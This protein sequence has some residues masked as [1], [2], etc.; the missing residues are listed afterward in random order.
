MDSPITFTPIADQTGTENVP[1]TAVTVSGGSDVTYSAI[2]LP[3]GLEIAPSSGEIT[4]TPS[5]GDALNSPYSVTVIG[6]QV[7]G[8]VTFS[9]EISFNWTVNSPVTITA[10][11]TQTNN[12]SDSVTVGIAATDTNSSTPTYSA[13]GLPPG[14]WINSG[15]GTISGIVTVGDSNI[16]TFNPTIIVNDGTCYSS[17]TFEWD[18][19]S[20]ISI[21]D[22]GDQ[23]N[24]VDDAVNLPIEATDTGGGTSFSF[25]ASGLPGGLSISSTDPSD[26]MALISGT[27]LQAD[28]SIGTYTTTVTVSDGTYSSSDTFTWTINALGR[29]TMTTPPNQTSTEGTSIGQLDLLATGSSLKYFAVGLPA[30]LVI[31]PSNGH[32]TGTPGVGDAA[33][34]PYTVT[35]TAT[36]GT[37]SAQESFV[38]TINSPVTLAGI[39]DQTGNE[40]GTVT[41]SVSG[42]FT[43]SPGGGQSSC[44]CC[45][46]G[47][48]SGSSGSL[49]YT[50]VGLPPGLA[51]N[52]G[53]GT[54]SGTLAVGDAVN[55]PYTVTVIANNGTYS[56]SQTFTWTVNC[57]ITF[58]SVPADQSNV[59]GDNI[60]PESLSVQ[61][62]D[63]HGETITYSATGLPYGLVLD[64]HTGAISGT[65]PPGDA[66]YGPYSVTLTASDG[67]YIASQS[68]SWTIG[69]P[70]TIT[71]PGQEE[72]TEGQTIDVPYEISA[73]TGGLLSYFATGLP[74][75]LSLDCTAI[76]ADLSGTIPNSIKVAGSY[77]GQVNACLNIGGEYFEASTG[78]VAKVTS[79]ELNTAYMIA[80]AGKAGGPASGSEQP[81]MNPL[82]SL[83]KMIAAQNAHDL[84]VARLMYAQKSFLQKMFKHPNI[85]LVQEIQKLESVFPSSNDIANPNGLKIKAD[86]FGISTQQYQELYK[87]YKAA[88]EKFK[89]LEAKK[90]EQY[91][92]I[93]ARNKVEGWSS[94]NMRQLL[95]D[96]PVRAQLQFQ[97]FYPDPKKG[98]EEIQKSQQLSQLYD[99]ALGGL[100]DLSKTNEK[101]QALFAK[102][103]DDAITKMAKQLARCVPDAG[104]AG[105][106]VCWQ[107]WP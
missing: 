100:E 73:P 16:G 5:V 61:A 32:I 80:Q 22:P 19:N 52:T 84:A 13:Q 42:S 101:M 38:W 20:P 2:N 48:P 35:V 17:T 90:D 47:C 82:K 34:S 58:T 24:T 6:E 43:A 39:A 93:I 50:A 81:E 99:Q 107:D 62:T 1:I 106:K 29:V 78:V 66:N 95:K 30:G 44:C 86:R 11:A 102:K 12:E 10:P 51:I 75:G 85:Y 18:V 103:P 74:S 70:I 77:N 28:L 92:A 37:N 69:S 98:Y 96:D 65:V 67:T 105:N 53:N 71:G 40:N 91:K 45:C 8:G 60:T 31:N 83:G 25:I 33:Y 64:P 97:D 26:P 23:A 55:S 68:L 76:R 3:L 27:I 41:L 89:A 9:S 56:A 7:S 4:G 59:E 79:P 104:N 87:M 94:A 46:N 36:D 72:F 63:S 54:I 49:T 14:L 88:D 57:P 21:S 15:N